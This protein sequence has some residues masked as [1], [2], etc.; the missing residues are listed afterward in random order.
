M[1]Y[2]INSKEEL[3]RRLNGKPLFMNNEL[4][5]KKSW[6]ILRLFSKDID[7]LDTLPYPIV[8]HC[9][10]DDYTSNYYEVE[11]P[12]DRA[13]VHYGIIMRVKADMA[14]RKSTEFDKKFFK[15]T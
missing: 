13:L 5:Y 4:I 2:L 7:L 14:K 3:T 10:Y 15:N 6:G 12:F 1:I 8:I 9:T 11:V